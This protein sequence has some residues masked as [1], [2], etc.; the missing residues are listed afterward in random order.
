MN[1]EIMHLASLAVTDLSFTFKMAHLTGIF[2][3]K[4]LIS[5]GLFACVRV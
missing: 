5:D 2:D 3:R 1:N 4:A